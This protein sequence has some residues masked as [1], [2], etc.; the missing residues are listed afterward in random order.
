MVNEGQ[1][2]ESEVLFAF[3]ERQSDK[4]AYFSVSTSEGKG[5]GKGPVTSLP[6]QIV[7]RKGTPEG[8]I[9]YSASLPKELNKGESLTLSY[10]AVY[11]HVLKPLPEKITQSD[12]QLVLFQDS[13]HFLAPYPVKTQSVTLTLPG[14]RIE[15]YSN[16][17][18]TKI[19]GS[20]IKYGP[21]E[22]VPQFSYVPVAVHFESNK[23]FAVARELEREI[24]ISHWGN[25]QI[26]EHYK[27]AHDGAQSKGE[28]SRSDIFV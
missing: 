22:N 13:A 6:L 15:S 28:F 2:T 9:F 3:V 18:N 4:L 20:E 11:T 19:Q 12:I 23:P 7:Q 16:I 10:L 14:A 25:V 8:L 26:T 17:E 1:K 24:E 27:L 21:Y 5:K